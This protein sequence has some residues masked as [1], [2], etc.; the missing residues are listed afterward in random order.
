MLQGLFF[1]DILSGFSNDYGLGTGQRKV[2][3]MIVTIFKTV[4]MYQF[5]LIV[6]LLILCQLRDRDILAPGRN[7][8]G[9][10]DEA[11]WVCRGFHASCSN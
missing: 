8:G 5:T 6:K 2:V 3:S 9:R 4:Q 7:G 1:R 11:N 10:L